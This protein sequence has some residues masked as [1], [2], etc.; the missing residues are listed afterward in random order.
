MHLT[1]K[2]RLAWRGIKR[3][4]REETPHLTAIWEDLFAARPSHS[5][6]PRGLLRMPRRGEPEILVRLGAIGLALATTLVLVGMISR[7]IEVMLA[8][9][10]TMGLLPALLGAASFG[11]RPGHSHRRR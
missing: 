9:I 11:S 6:G 7:Q 2:Q 5:S 10:T 3:S 4:L 1:I 8:G